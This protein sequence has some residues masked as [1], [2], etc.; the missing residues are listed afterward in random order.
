MNARVIKQINNTKN[1]N[2]IVMANLY[3]PAESLS[4]N[5]ENSI[6][7]YVLKRTFFFPFPESLKKEVNITR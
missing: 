5:N 7:Q 4:L 3:S 2:S 1:I 6:L